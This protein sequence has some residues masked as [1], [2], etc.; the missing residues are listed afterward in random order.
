MEKSSARLVFAA[1]V[2]V[3]VGGVDLTSA[4]GKDCV[5]VES[6][7]VCFG[8]KMLRNVMKRLG[9]EKS[10][11]VLPGIEIAQI[12]RS[13]E[14][15]ERAFNEIDGQDDGLLARLSRYLVNHEL[16]INLGE[17]VEKSTLQDA[18]R[19]TLR[20]VGDVEGSYDRKDKYELILHTFTL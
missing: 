11:Q 18:V 1:V 4:V 8:E 20:D 5:G 13:D 6:S 15:R 3:L 12:E 7:L 19:S 14:E 17:L 9:N 2:V 16:K 10:L